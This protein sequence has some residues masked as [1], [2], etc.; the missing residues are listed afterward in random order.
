MRTLN[1][2]INKNDVSKQTWETINNCEIS[3]ELITPEKA[4]TFIDSFEGNR[5]L[6]PRTVNYLSNLMTENK[7]NFTHEGMLF[8]KNN[9][10]I[11]GNHRCHA[12]VK[13]KTSYPFI[14]CKKFPSFIFANLDSGRKR[15]GEDAVYVSGI[16]INAREQAA[17]AKFILTILIN[18]E[19]SAINNNS[20][21]QNYIS[22]QDIVDFATKTNNLSNSVNIAVDI[23]N[24]IKYIRPAN[25]G[26][27]HFVFANLI[28]NQLADNFFE[29]YRTGSGMASTHPVHLLR[30]ILRKDAEKRGKTGKARY[31][32]PAKIAYLKAAWNHF[33]IGEIDVQTLKPTKEI[34][35]INGAKINVGEELNKILNNE[36][37][38]A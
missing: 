15:S 10:L 27:F 23:N 30:E 11:D 5:P 24:S 37:V 1:V 34:H 20:A 14:I 17:I 4:Q 26:G 29:L 7:W 21:N 35:D 25:I 36:L 31:S 33:V 22:N 19:Q 9:R 12:I 8:D 16:T 18:R 32:E 2:N 38:E 28:N 6:K 3:I 13:S